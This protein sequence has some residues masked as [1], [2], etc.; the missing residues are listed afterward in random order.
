MAFFETLGGKII[1]AGQSIAQSTK[2]F[3]DV[4]KLNSAASDYEKQIMDLYT[5]IGK[6]YYER[7]KNDANAEEQQRIM[8]INSLFRQIEDL[9]RQVKEIEGLT[10]CPNCGGDVPRD[11]LFCNNCGCKIVKETAGRH[12]SNCGMPIAADSMFCAHCGTKV[13]QEAANVANAEVPAGSQKLCPVCHAVLTDEDV[14]CSECGTPVSQ[15]TQPGETVNTTP[16][17]GNEEV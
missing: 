8:A 16:E 10:K 3:A 5:I 12:C 13:E 4:T 2:N 17:T 7:H 14:F 15:N 9:K 11:A 1:N 6:A